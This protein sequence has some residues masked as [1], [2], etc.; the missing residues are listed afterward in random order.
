[1]FRKSIIGIFIV[2]LI[3]I[4]YLFIFK[5]DISLDEVK[6]QLLL[7]KKIEVIKEPVLTKKDETYPVIEDEQSIQKIVSILSNMYLPSSNWSI[8]SEQDI[9]YL[10]L[11]DKKNQLISIIKIASLPWEISGKGYHHK[12]SLDSKWINSL[13]KIFKED[14]NINIY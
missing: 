3:V 4:G 8:L 12:F 13:R 7:T 10:K 11:F 1:M 2:L 14:Y 5:K 6:T 9:Y